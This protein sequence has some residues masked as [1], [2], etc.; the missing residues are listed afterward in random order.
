VW[1]RHRS[2]QDIPEEKENRLLIVTKK[3][4]DPNGSSK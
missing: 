1:E 2:I 3:E 4:W